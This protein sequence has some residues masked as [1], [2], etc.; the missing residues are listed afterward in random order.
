MRKLLI[1]PFLFLSLLALSQVPNFEFENWDN[2]EIQSPADWS[3]NGNVS[4]SLDKTDGTFAVKLE[5]KISSEQEIGFVANTPITNNFNGGKPYTDIPLVMRFDAKYDLAQGDVAKAIAVFKASGQP[6]ATVDFS[7][8]GNTAD[9]FVT[10][11]I[12]IQWLISAV[13]D[14]IIILFVSND[15]DNTQL[16]GDGY[17]IVDN[18]I[19]ES[20]GIPDQQ[21]DNPS[22]E[23]WETTNVAHPTNWYTSSLIASELLGFQ[24]DVESV[25]KSTVSHSGFSLLLQNKFFDGELFPGVAFTGNSFDENFPPAFAVS[26][27]WKNLQGYYKYN[28]ENNDS[29]SIAALMYQN[30][31]IIGS[32]QFY[33]TNLVDDIS[34][35]STPI[36]Y[37]GGS[38]PD[39]AT[40]IIASANFENA[41]G[42][43]SKLW[44]DKLSFTNNPASTEN[45][46]KTISVYPNPS[47][48]V[49]NVSVSFDA[50]NYYV[51]N[52]IG[53]EVILSESNVIDIS[54]LP[55]GSYFIRVTG[56]NNILTTKFVKS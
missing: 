20:I 19:F 51:F 54:E 22:F 53:E 14:S 43:N 16:N 9:T 7:M 13:P 55:S 50:E 17:L 11:K 41:R 10:Y 46:T 30:G 12:P 25:V 33:A 2:F 35:F 15:F 34:Y 4:Q 48:N 52:L 29:G 24:I 21:V 45:L 3:F 31:N 42:T 1:L 56:N 37:F 26:S 18:L 40:I 38:T 8:T 27:N 32:A 36:V 6:I 23:N 5:N 28:P 47:N 39:S 44:V 49:I